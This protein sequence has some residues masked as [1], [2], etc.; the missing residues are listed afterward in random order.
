VIAADPNLGYKL[1]DGA[2]WKHAD[3]ILTD[4]FTGSTQ[5]DMIV[6]WSDGEVTLYLGGMTTDPQKPF[7]SEKQLAKP[8][9]VWTHAKSI[10]SLHRNQ[11]VVLWSDGEVTLYPVVTEAGFGSEIQ[12][13]APNALWRD[14]AS[15]IAGDLNS[16]IVVWSDGEVSAYVDVQENRLGVER[17]LVPPNDTWKHVRSISNGYDLVVRWSDGEL[18]LYGAPAAFGLTREFQVLPPN[19][20]WTHATVVAGY[21]DGIIVRWVDGEL[22]Y[23]PRL[24]DGSGPLGREIQLVAP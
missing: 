21:G 4:Q 9:S 5:N 6:K 10:A 1:G 20:L 18:S 16:L 19:D 2:L 23:Y 11:V 14:H 7:R 12:L 15:Y 8:G 22:S 17:Q 3:L 13:I 24:A